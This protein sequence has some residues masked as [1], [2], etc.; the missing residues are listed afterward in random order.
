MNVSVNEVLFPASMQ[1][2]SAYSTKT[3]KRT[4]VPTRGSRDRTPPPHTH[5]QTHNTPSKLP[6][7]L[8]FFAF[9]PLH[10]HRRFCLALTLNRLRANML[11]LSTSHVAAPPLTFNTT[12]LLEMLRRFSHKRWDETREHSS[13]P[14]P[15]LKTHNFPPF[16][17][18]TDF[19]SQISKRMSRLSLASRHTPPPTR[20][21]L[22]IICIF[23][24]NNFTV[25]IWSIGQF[26][27]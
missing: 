25:M 4:S 7:W 19:T 16:A 22:H 13:R 5:T 9:K 23:I 21:K 6:R 26:T 1:T 2:R 3:D 8:S 27:G 17:H 10:T 20:R 12:P 18:I 24:L 15:L 14:W 11:R